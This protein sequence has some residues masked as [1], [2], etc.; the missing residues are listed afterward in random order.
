M[1][2]TIT[3]IQARPQYIQEYDEALLQ[4]FFGSPD[5]EGVLTGG[6][7][8]DPELF[9]IP[10]Y[11]QATSPLQSAVAATFATPEQRQAFF[12]R[13]QPYFMD[14]EGF[15]RYLPEAS[16]ELSTGAQ[17]I[18]DAL[19]DYFPEAETYLQAWIVTGKQRAKS[20]SS[21]KYG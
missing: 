1:S 2:D 4:R 8:D 5:S 7:I 10:D 13:Y 17:T 21:I 18:E 6:L 16:S 20:S 11:V 19:L 3:Q 15:A 12:D 14:E 9:Q